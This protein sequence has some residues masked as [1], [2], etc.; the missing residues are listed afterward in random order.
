MNKKLNRLWRQ[1]TAD[2]KRFGI[3]LSLVCVGLLLWGRLILLEKVPRIATADP[4]T[5]EQAEQPPVR[6]ARDRP[7][8]A[9]DLPQALALDLFALRPDRYNPISDPESGEPGVQSVDPDADEWE[10]REA[11]MDEARGMAL[12][13]VFRGS[14]PFAVIDGL[15]VH[16]GDAVGGFELIELDDRQRLAKLRSTLFQDLVVILRMSDG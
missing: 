14:Q 1:M 4:D 5:A 8:V 6:A 10:R 12:Q 15:R 2:K 13:G 9:V 11:L 16:V 7:T 3:M